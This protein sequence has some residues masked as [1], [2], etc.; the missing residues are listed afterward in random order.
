MDSWAQKLGIIELGQRV[1][2]SMVYENLPTGLN[3]VVARIKRAQRDDSP[4]QCSVCGRE[5]LQ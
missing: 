4:D 5:H 3:T 1:V 2:T